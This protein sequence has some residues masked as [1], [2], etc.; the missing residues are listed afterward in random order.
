MESTVRRNLVAR[1]AQGIGHKGESEETLRALEHLERTGEAKL[2]WEGKH[3]MSAEFIPPE[4]RRQA[5]KPE[6]DD[7]PGAEVLEEATPQEPEPP[8]LA[9]REK[10]ASIISDLEKK[11]A[12]AEKRAA[13]YKAERDAAVELADEYEAEVSALREKLQ[14]LEKTVNEIDP[15]T[16]EILQRYHKL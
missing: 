13:H 12:E 3:L 10:L 11:L 6:P 5:D 9:A 8:G 7:D 16:A 2:S 14:A 15:R 1:I 4:K